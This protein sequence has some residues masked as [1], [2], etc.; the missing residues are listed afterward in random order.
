MGGLKRVLVVVELL[1]LL[2]TTWWPCTE[3]AVHKYKKLPIVCQYE[4]GGDSCYQWGGREGMFASGSARMLPRFFVFAKGL[5]DGRSQIKLDKL[6]FVREGSNTGSDS[7]SSRRF[8]Y[9]VIFEGNDYRKRVGYP[10]SANPNAQNYCCTEEIKG[11]KD[12][13]REL[14]VSTYGEDE[15][16][17]PRI[18]DY[19]FSGNKTESF[20]PNTVDITRTGMYYMLFIVCDKSLTKVYVDGETV[21][22][23]PM[24]Y[25]PGMVA[26]KLAFYA[27][28]S[29]CYLVLGVIWFVQYTRYWRDILQLQNCITLVLFLGMSETATWYF[30][31]VNFNSTG[32]RPIGVTMWAVLLG[33]LRKALSRMLVLV[34][35]MGYGVVRPTLGGLTNKVLFLGITDFVAICSFD[36]MQYVGAVDDKA[37]AAR[38]FLTLP[39]AVLDAIFILW[40]FTSLSRTLSQLQARRQTA[41]LE[42]YRKFTNVLAITVVVS[43]AWIAYEFYLKVED[44]YVENWE[45]DWIVHVVWQALNFGLLCTICYLWAPNQNAT[46]YAYSEDVGEED[47]GS[48]TAPLKASGAKSGAGT[49]EL[50]SESAL[51]AEKPKQPISTDVFSLDDDMEEGKLE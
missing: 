50:S 42:L 40:I 5:N 46:R 4:N 24:G 13:T 10:S 39:V 34:V 16:P 47:E 49:M 45:M 28:L 37:P 11:R 38:M 26:P 27:F 20:S 29:F 23:N 32:S 36:M 43:V 19:E 18:L 41:K 51:K 8:V 15:R 44:Q 48:E 33:A 22:K 14:V 21:W 6:R 35:S 30:D 3:A 31:F 25:L 1:F 17:W 12:C 2:A 7:E 9:V